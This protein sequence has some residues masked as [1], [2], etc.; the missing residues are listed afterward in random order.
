LTLTA[1]GLCLL[2]CRPKEERAVKAFCKAFE[3]CQPENFAEQFESV[4]DCRDDSLTQLEEAE[5]EN[6][7]E[8]GEAF[9]VAIECAADVNAETCDFQAVVGECGDE[10][11]EA[12]DLCPTLD[13]E[14]LDLGAF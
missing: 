4:N 8:C 9:A 6:G 12:L 13:L 2:S 3:D 14:T 5:A 7:P 1:L 10:I 11:I